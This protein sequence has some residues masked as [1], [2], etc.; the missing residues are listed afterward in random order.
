MKVDIIQWL[1][2]TGGKNA[3]KR[4]HD[5]KS[6][7]P[8]DTSVPAAK[9]TL[10]K[11]DAAILKAA[12]GLHSNYEMLVRIIRPVSKEIDEFHQELY[13]IYHT[14][15]P[16]K[17]FDKIHLASGNLLIK[18]VAITNSKV[19]NK[20]ESKFDKIYSAETELLDA[21]KGLNSLDKSMDANDV[22]MAVEKVHTK[23]QKLEE[24]F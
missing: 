9:I 7:M 2:D 16:G 8:P 12:E 6:K 18:A 5:D 17:K 14:Y 13:I 3:I 1:K 10:S 19:P 24:L 20:L 23:Y 22:E 15:L 4:F 21:V 11:N